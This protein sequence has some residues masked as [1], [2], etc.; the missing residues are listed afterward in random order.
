MRLKGAAA[1]ATPGAASGAGS[2][3]AGSTDKSQTVSPAAGPAS[4]AASAGN[5]A[6]G[7]PGGA[8]DFQQML[9]HLPAASLADLHKGDAVIILST[10]GA[11][12]V[13]TVITLVSGVEPILQ[14]A[15]SASSAMM[16]APWTMGAPSGDAGG[17]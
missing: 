16:L 15:P 10:E 2:A 8:P 4:G 7:R 11:A 5:G 1:G 9:S 14:A 6:G 12:G 17:P 13:G 3:K